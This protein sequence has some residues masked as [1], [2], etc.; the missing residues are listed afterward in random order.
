M[1]LI[2]FTFSIIFI[3]WNK[4]SYFLVLNG[5]VFTYFIKMLAMTIKIK[6]RRNEVLEQVLSLGVYSFP[7]IFVAAIFVGGVSA[8]SASY[9]F[10]NFIP[11]RYIGT[12]VGVSVILELAPVIMC[13]LLAGRISSG[14]ATQMASM[15]TNEEI[16]VLESFNFNHFEIYGMPKMWACILTFPILYYF[17]CLIALLVGGLQSYV[18]LDVSYEKYVYGL[19]V[20][21]KP[22]FLFIGTVKVF[23]FA[24]VI[25]VLGY[26][27][28]LKSSLGSKGIGLASMR[29]V[30]LASI[31]ILIFDFVL[32]ILMLDI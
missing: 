21:F 32:N 1:V 11:N 18:F 20:L 13:L 24:I 26:Y 27:C 7:L 14:I 17:F 31:G 5:E 3:L 19:R 4:V 29:A 16:D 25:S 30:V 8:E 23:S 28:G 15:K 22:Y 2:Y 6:R 10:Q 12:A 9:Q